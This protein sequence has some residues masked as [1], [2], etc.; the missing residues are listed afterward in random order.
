MLVSSHY[1]FDTRNSTSLTGFK[2]TGQ[3]DYGDLNRISCPGMICACVCIYHYGDLYECY[4]LNCGSIVISGPDDG[5][6]LSTVPF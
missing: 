1:M 3:E 5:H 2:K 4:V 6:F